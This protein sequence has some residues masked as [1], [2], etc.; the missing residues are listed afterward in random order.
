MSWIEKGRSW[1]GDLSRCI[2][3][4]ADAFFFFL[5]MRRPDEELRMGDLL[6]DETDRRLDLM[7]FLLWLDAERSSAILL[8]FCCTFK[9]DKVGSV[10]A[11][12]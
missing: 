3:R 8:M 2:C 7:R 11:Y 10:G 5:E 6:D 4:S 12:Y 9:G 1:Y